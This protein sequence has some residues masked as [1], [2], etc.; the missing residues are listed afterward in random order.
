MAENENVV[1]HGVLKKSVNPFGTIG[2]TIGVMSGP[3]RAG[4]IFRRI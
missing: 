3:R 1:K 4:G 2:H